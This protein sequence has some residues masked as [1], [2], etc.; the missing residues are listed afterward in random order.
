NTGAVWGLGNNGNGQLGDNSTTRRLA[1]VASGLTANVTA[2]SAGNAHSLA[3]KN[4][5][6]VWAWGLNNNGQLGN[7][8]NTGTQQMVPVQVGGVGGTGLL[9]NISGISASGTN[10]YSLAVDNTGVVYAWGLN[11]A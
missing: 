7:N 3:R 4:D 1:P 5:G 9:A 11:G 6:T 10:N 2:I 8:D